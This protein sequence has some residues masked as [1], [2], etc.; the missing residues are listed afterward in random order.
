MAK[1]YLMLEDLSPENLDEGEMALGWAID[2][3]TEDKAMP[4]GDQP[5][6]DAQAAMAML[7]AAL[8]NAIDK[9]QPEAEEGSKIL[10]LD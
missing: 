4:V 8:E 10:L 3:G 6:T 7:V 1:C 2:W 9:A 5:M